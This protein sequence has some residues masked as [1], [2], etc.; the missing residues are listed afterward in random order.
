MSFRY[1]YQ[2]LI[3]WFALPQGYPEHDPM[4]EAERFGDFRLDTRASILFHQDKEVPVQPRVFTLLVYLYRNRDRI[5]PKDELLDAIWPEVVVTDASLQR[6][7]SLIRGILRTGGLE[8]VVRNYARRGYRFCEEAVMDREE[9]DHILGTAGSAG[10]AHEYLEAGEWEKAENAFREADLENDLSAL[11][12]ECWGHALQCQ[13]KLVE[14]RLPLE[15]AAEAW[16]SEGDP[17]SVARISICLARIE[18]EATRVSLAAGWLRQAHEILKTR[19]MC[20]Q[21]GHLA[22]MRARLAAFNGDFDATRC[23][24]EKAIKIGRDLELPELCSL[25]LLYKGIACQA[26]GQATKGIQLQDQAAAMVISGQ[27]PPLLGGMVYCGL[28]ASCANTADW[29]R[30][31]Q[32]T[33]SFTRWCHR[34]QIHT[35]VGSCVLNRA[36]VMYVK[37]EFEQ[38]LEE[39]SVNRESLASSAPWA[40]GDARRILGDIFLLRGELDRAETAYR[41]AHDHGWDPNPGYARLLEA[42]GQADAAV[43]SLQAAIETENWVAGERRMIYRAAL[44]EIAARNARLDLARTSMEKLQSELESSNTGGI[45]GILFISRAELCLAESRYAQAVSAFREALA[46]WQKLDAPVEIARTRVRLA[47]ALINNGDPLGAGLELS[48][49]EAVFRKMEANLYLEKIGEL[50]RAI[51]DPS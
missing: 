14:S 46:V 15:R 40:E 34:Q 35:F 43:R 11:D 51:P 10:L 13:G 42:R 12:L 8:G 44:V 32:W 49:A 38:A 41:E 48:A 27:I 29:P 26:A 9:K 22:W 18:L 7:V 39:L 50:K 37:G 5:I 4:G 1:P 47:G 30:A 45:P 24:A 23:H 25:G 2:S 19:P 20:E 6:A 33:E 21:H 17:E 36:Q 3:I 28:V 16:N 31:A